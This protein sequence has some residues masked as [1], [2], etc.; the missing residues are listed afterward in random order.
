MK[1]YTFSSQW[2][3]IVADP[4]NKGLP[5]SK[6]VPVEFTTLNESFVENV[7]DFFSLIS[8]FAAKLFDG[9]NLIVPF[10]M[11]IYFMDTRHYVLNP[12][13]RG[14]IPDLF[15][16][17]TPFDDGNNYITAELLETCLLN[18]EVSKKH[19]IPSIMKLYVDIE[20]TGA[21]SQFYDKFTPRFY[22]ALFLKYIWK[23]NI[24]I[25]SFVKAAQSERTLKFFNLML[26]DAIFLLDE[27]IKYLHIM[28]Q[29]EMDIANPMVWSTFSNQ[30]QLDKQTEYRNAARQTTTYM[31]L[32]NETVYMM[33]YMSKDAPE[34]FLRKEM[35]ER[36]AYMLNYFLFELAGEKCQNLKVASPEK[37]NFSAKRLIT[38]ITDT[39]INFDKYDKFIE[40]IAIDERSYSDKLFKRAIDIMKKIQKR[41]S[42][43][44]E[45]F[46]I[47]SEKAKE[48]KQ[49]VMEM[50]VD[51][52]E[53][54]DEYLDPITYTLMEDP[55]IL[56]SKQVMDRSSIEKHLLNDSTDPFNRQPLTSD[57][58]VPDDKLKKE[59]QEWKKKTLEE[60]RK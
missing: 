47:L 5:L 44:I 37:Y 9:K 35:I 12:Y 34:P 36:V 45:R 13:V 43:H 21:S 60:A 7:I 29:Y 49:K 52:G 40:A 4:Q 1:F 23:Y 22:I 31:Q 18:N 39:Y 27:S 14:K 11:M 33:K 16:T 53:I 6:D 15:A 59:I 30:V 57:M 46:V 55:V 10:N 42:S 26:N 56:P 50:E 28:N 2:L 54:P 51:L 38:E 17:L 24:F 3:M 25:E 32:A 58:L 20:R 8:K 48:A 19:L 41:E